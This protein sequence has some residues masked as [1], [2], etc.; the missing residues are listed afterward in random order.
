[1]MVG[2]DAGIRTNMPL[3]SE[4]SKQQKPAGGHDFHK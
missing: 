3:A 2:K 4:I 1:M